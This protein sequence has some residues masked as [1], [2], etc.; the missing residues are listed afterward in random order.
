MLK[1]REVYIERNIMNIKTILMSLIVVA[2]VAGVADAVK[3]T[4]QGCF[5]MSIG[6]AE[7]MN[8][9]A[10]SEDKEAIEPVLREWAKIRTKCERRVE[11]L[12]LDAKQALGTY[13]IDADLFTNDELKRIIND[14]LLN[15]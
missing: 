5:T 7:K 14:V 11:R 3:K 10:G 8:K 6:W 13:A 15:K 1:N 4:K 12:I 2:S 9:L